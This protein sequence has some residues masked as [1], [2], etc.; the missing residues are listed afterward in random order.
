MQKSRALKN[1]SLSIAIFGKSKE[2]KQVCSSKA[3]PS[4]HVG[5]IFIAVPTA[6]V[7]LPVIAISKIRHCLK[8]LL[9]FI[10]YIKLLLIDFSF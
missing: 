1:A 4:L 9:F 7:S 8:S 5:L 6:R 2:L 10:L 3:G